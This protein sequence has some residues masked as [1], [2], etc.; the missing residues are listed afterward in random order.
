MFTNLNLTDPDICFN[1]IRHEKLKQIKIKENNFRIE[2]IL[3]SKIAKLSCRIQEM[4]N[5][6]F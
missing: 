2:R 4:G 5:L 1:V 3:A 6:F